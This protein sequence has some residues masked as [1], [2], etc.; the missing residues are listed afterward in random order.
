M[1]GLMSQENNVSYLLKIAGKS[2]WLLALSAFFSVLSGLLDFFPF[3]MLYRVMLYLFG[4]TPDLEQAKKFG[5]YAAI[6]II[7]K[8]FMMI[9][10]LTFSHIGAFNT[11]YNV[12]C[13]LSAHIAKVHLG[14]FNSTA[15]GKIKKTIIED[16][17]RM[18]LLLAHQIPDL[19]KAIAA[20]L[21]VFIYL[22]SLNH[23]LALNLL[24]PIALGIIVMAI[25]M[26]LSGNYMA[27]YHQ[28][29]EK[30]NAAIM[31][32]VNGMNVMKTFNVTAKGFRQYSDT[33]EEYHTMWVDCTKSQGPPYAIFLVL[34]DSAILFTF[35][36][37]G[38]LYLNNNLSVVTFLFF[39]VMGMIFLSSLKALIGFSMSITQIVSGVGR[40]KEI[41]TV[42]EQKFGDL[43]MDSTDLNLRFEDVSFAYETKAV[44][45][46]INLEVKKGSLIAFVGS[47]GSGKST[48]AQLVP[49]FWDVIKGQ[50]AINGQPI[51]DFLESALMDAVSFVF[52]EAFMLHDTIRMNVA[53][54]KPDAD[55]T[56][57]IA[58]CQA[59]QIHD[60]IMSLP[61]GYDTHLGEAGIKMSGGE[62]QR[63]CI[64]RAI[65]KNSPIIIFDEATSYT[66]IENERKIQL[67]L[68]ELLRNKT[69]IMI[70]HRLHTIVNA[71]QICVFDKG[72]IVEADTHQNLLQQNGFYAKLWQTYVSSSIE[73][74]S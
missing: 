10:S 32:Y 41:M 37:G 68:N 63:I 54:G 62:R 40:V 44:L 22:F 48:A 12:R 13:L 46:G 9:L 29:I 11:L 58:A 38:Y 74:V 64:A 39:L 3:I 7:L 27:L 50:I 47:S 25:G 14:F 15:S 70:A 4:T 69:T 30:L 72:K 61:K 18:E 2:K 33:V 16:T 24:V 55:D 17:E 31:Q 43:P 19:T 71:D 65:L 26:K 36:L 73:E 51:N 1:E 23:L 60:F 28:L 45:H 52:Q 49:R 59:A 5:I 34:I 67:A 53:V 8:F 66:D 6:A 56:A 20:P 21:I 57:I 42:P 35:P